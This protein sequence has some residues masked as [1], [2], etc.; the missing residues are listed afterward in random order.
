MSTDPGLAQT[1]AQA[2]PDIKAVPEQASARAAIRDAAGAAVRDLDR[3]SPLA[4]EVL[5]ALAQQVLAGLG[6]PERFTGFAMV[7]CDN[8]FWASQFAA[9][10]M[11]RRV[12]LLPRCLTSE[13]LCQGQWQGPRLDCAGCGACVVTDLA[14]EARALGY[15]VVVSEGTSA[16]V[17]SVL[18]GSADAVLGVACL[19]SLEKSFDRI[20]DIIAHIMTERN[21][22]FTKLNH[23]A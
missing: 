7:A 9:T 1:D 19:D 14:S 22:L 8:A 17:D 23:I 3:E 11:T 12:L 16:V 6:L 5:R 21:V 20:A 4:L 15:E 10:P 2:L 18:E 13:S